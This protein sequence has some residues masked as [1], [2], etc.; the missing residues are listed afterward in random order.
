MRGLAIACMLRILIRGDDPFLAFLALHHLY[1][2]VKLGLEVAA[3]LILYPTAHMWLRS[4][5]RPLAVV[6]ALVL[7]VKFEVPLQTHIVLVLG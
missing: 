3:P 2:E 5:Q 1:G 7:E 4:C 6:G